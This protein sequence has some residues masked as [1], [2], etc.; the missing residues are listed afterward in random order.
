MIGQRILAAAGLVALVGGCYFSGN[1]RVGLSPEST[2]TPAQ[3]PTAIVTPTAA[4]TL[5]A[6]TAE[7][8]RINFDRGAWGK[9]IIGNT[10]TKYLLWAAQSQTFTVTLSSNQSALAS[11]YSPDGKALYEQMAAGNTAAAKLP[12]NGDYLLEVRASG[13]YTV[14]VEIR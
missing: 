6:V 1:G 7:P 13:A 4:A 11:L 10:G 8:V 3:T 14:E 2:A 9:T 5:Q 12:A